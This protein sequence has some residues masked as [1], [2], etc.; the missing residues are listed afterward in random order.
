MNA[1]PHARDPKSLV[2]FVVG[3]EGNTAEFFV[4]KEVV[5]H[6]SKVFQAAFNSVFIEGATQSYRLED[7][8]PA[9]FKFMMQWL[10]SQR[11]N[12]LHHDPNHKCCGRDED[13]DIQQDTALVSALNRSLQRT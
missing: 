3:P 8:S 13:R 9:A 2:T 12:L 5:C 11:F 10:Y 1:N 7:V 4:H 6:H